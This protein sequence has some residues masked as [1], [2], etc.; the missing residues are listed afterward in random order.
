MPATF[1]R[2]NHPR[3]PGDSVQQSEYLHRTRAG[4]PGSSFRSEL[5]IARRSTDERADGCVAA[6]RIVAFR[7]WETSRNVEKPVEQLKMRYDTP[8][9]RIGDRVSNCVSRAP[10]ARRNR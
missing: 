2:R 6:R 5:K 8:Y 7:M 4:S 1:P 9:R 3:T 10:R